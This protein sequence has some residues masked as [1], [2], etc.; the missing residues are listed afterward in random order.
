LEQRLTHLVAQQV[1]NAVGVIERRASG[2]PGI[3]A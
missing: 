2:M 1:A 3:Q